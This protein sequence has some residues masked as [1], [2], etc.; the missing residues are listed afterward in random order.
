M[1]TG[2]P[3]GE[4]KT[5]LCGRAS[6]QYSVP[7]AS[8]NAIFVDY[9]SPKGL[10]A[11]DE[12]A[13]FEVCN[14]EGKAPLVLTCDHASA[15]IPRQLQSLGLDEASLARHI[16]YDIGIADVTRHLARR[17]DAVAVLSNF[18]RLIIDPN[19]KLGTASSIVEVSDG[20]TVPGNRDLTDEAVARRVDT[21]FKPYHEAVHQAIEARIAGADVPALIAMHSFTPVMEGVQ[22]PWQIGVLWNRDPRLPLP[23]IDRLRRHGLTVGDNEPYSGR[24]GHGYSQHRHGDDRGLANALIEVRQDLIDTHQGGE[25]WSALLASVF[26]E[27]LRDP[28]L[29]RRWNGQDKL[30]ATT[31]DQSR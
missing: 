17:L 11:A 27:V 4:G 28:S 18:S 15:F 6:G 13:P 26:S 24:D 21:F 5:L 20:V 8:D 1:T 14:P 19:R 22:R 23:L 31:A 25:H 2:V 9:F 29:Y 3:A 30:S 12:A 10:L 7:M 16:A